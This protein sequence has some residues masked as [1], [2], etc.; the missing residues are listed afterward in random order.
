M[1]GWIDVSG[2][3]RVPKGGG[4]VGY[5]IRIRTKYLGTYVA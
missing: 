2:S 4:R 1:F 5:A 3:E